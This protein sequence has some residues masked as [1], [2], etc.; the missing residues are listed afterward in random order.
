MAKNGSI[1]LAIDRAYFD[2]LALESVL[3][4]TWHPNVTSEPVCIFRPEIQV[5]QWPF[6]DVN[7]VTWAQAAR[8]GAKL[9]YNRGFVGGHFDGH[10]DIS[11]GGYGIQC[12]G[13]GATWYDVNAADIWMP[14][15]RLQT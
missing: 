9:C 1:L 10:Q 3:K 15:G 14:D 12:S 6:D 4:T 13:S 7:T 5:T 11:K 8:V 2:S